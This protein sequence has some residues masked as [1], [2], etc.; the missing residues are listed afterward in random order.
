MTHITHV[1]PHS[2]MGHFYLLVRDET[3]IRVIFCLNDSSNMNDSYHIFEDSF[4][5]ES[6]F[7]LYVTTH[8]YMSHLFEMTRH[9]RMIFICEDS[10][11]YDSLFFLYLT[12]HL[13]VS[14]FF[15]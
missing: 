15:E 13:Y 12:T 1:K 7:C 11:T 10:F 8:L 4:I 5:H 14:C 2:Y 6:F 9:M 3:F